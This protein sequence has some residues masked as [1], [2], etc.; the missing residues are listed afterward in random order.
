MNDLTRYT[1]DAVKQMEDDKVYDIEKSKDGIDI[2]KVQKEN[3]KIYIGSKYKAQK[4]IDKFIVEAGEYN[5]ETI[6]FCFG[7]GTGEHINELLKVT[8]KDNKII[9]IEPELRN[10][11]TVITLNKIVNILN[12]DRVIL[13]PKYNEMDGFFKIAIPELLANN[14]KFLFFA[15][16]KEVY[17]EEAVDCYNHY[18]N[19]VKDI[20]IEINTAAYHSRHFFSSSIN[21]LKYIL[22]STELSSLKDL[23]KGKTAVIVSAG[24]SLE[25][26]INLLKEYKEKCIIIT[27]G[28]TLKS[29]LNIEVAP[30]F[31]CTVDPDV[32][33]YDVMRGAFECTAPMLFSEL[34]YS[35]VLRDYKGKKVFFSE[36]STTSVT[37]PLINTK[38]ANLFQGG[39]VAHTCTA[40]GVYLGCENIIFIGQDLAY[41]NDKT[42]A[43]IA[44]NSEAFNPNIIFVKDIYGD[45]VK[46]SM[47]LDYYRIALQ[48]E[49]KYFRDNK[50]KCNFINSTEG[51]ASIEGTEVIPL[52]ESLGS[53]TDDIID[54]SKLD[55]ILNESKIENNISREKLIEKLQNTLE[56][57]SIIKEKLPAG[58][59]ICND[60]LNNIEGI[61]NIDIDKANKKLEK[62][63]EIMNKHI[64]NINLIKLLL[65]PA[66]GE[67]RMNLKYKGNYEDDR[68]TS[69]LKV[70][71][72]TKVLYEGIACAIEEAYPQISQVISKLEEERD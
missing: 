35:G 51:G 56:K 14:T 20:I 52:K 42:H 44:G 64:E 39:S 62:I 18:V 4:D 17:M 58:I 70:Y 1:I 36:M 67:V 40:L 12:N 54:K 43:D 46:T 57:L 60:I 31:V 50:I 28:R 41:T 59:K 22:K 29:L 61:K 24:P 11:K 19:C 48:N 68:N 21:N 10:I 53:L 45:K 72:K 8:G 26:N 6:F 16:Y 25:K 49:I 15:N 47:V 32:P 5:T 71:M 63:D 55:I 34:T 33:A 30:D 9:I 13:T 3:K 27:G 66:I 65:S 2:L 23:Y 69:I 7:I 38:C 37:E